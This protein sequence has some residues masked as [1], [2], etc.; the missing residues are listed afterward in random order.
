MLDDESEPCS[1][2]PRASFPSRI[3]AATISDLHR[4]DW[5]ERIR[6]LAQPPLLPAERVL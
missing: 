4:A 3:L 2:R 1:A 5:S 6:V